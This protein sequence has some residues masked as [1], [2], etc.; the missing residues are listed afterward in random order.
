VRPGARVTYTLTATNVSRAVVKGATATDDL[1]AV[2]AHASLDAV[3]AGATLTGTTLTWRIPELK[4][5][6]VARLTYRATLDDDASGA[7]VTNVVTPS[8]PGRCVQACTTVHNTPP[9]PTEPNE[10]GLPST[11]GPTLVAVGVG[12]AL[13]VV[14]GGLVLWSRRRKEE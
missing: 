3:P 4:P 14:G 7:R 9:K 13:L 8:D 5:G 10:P 1:T 12:L 6:Q 2:L 11:G